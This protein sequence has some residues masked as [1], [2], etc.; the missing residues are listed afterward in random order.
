MANTLPESLLEM[1]YFL[2]LRDRFALELGS[3]NFH[4]LKPSTRKENWYGF[5]QGFVS[6]GGS[7]TEIES[8]LRDYLHKTYPNQ[9][10]TLRAFLLQFKVVK[11]LSR[12]SHLTPPGWRSPY[13]RCDVSL[14]PSPETGLS[15]HE[16]LL[17][18]STI[19]GTAVSYVC[20]MIFSET[21]VL[22]TP[23]LSDLCFVDVTS[24]PDGWNQNERH[25]IC[26]QEKNSQPTWK[27]KP[28][29]G[30]LLDFKELF[31]QAKPFKLEQIDEYLEGLAETLTLTNEER[32]ARLEK[33]QS[34]DP[35]R[36]GVRTIKIES[37]LETVP[38]TNPLPPSLTIFAS[39]ES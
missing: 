39:P 37:L 22:K 17:R 32:L 29:N 13:Y 35:V 25:H 21:D 38:E 15:Q 31:R 4:V 24:A 14:S 33:K 34:R 26:F 10:L 20:P 16:T 12:V 23:Q 1:F 36:K 11:K 18:A 2:E 9:N 28:V 8:N 19:P 27:S 6:A 5:D 30:R 3:Q 7:R